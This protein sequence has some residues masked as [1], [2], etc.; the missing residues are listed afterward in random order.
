MAARY[1]RGTKVWER[2]DHGV[3]GSRLLCG[4]PEWEHLDCGCQ[5][6][7]ATL[8]AATWDDPYV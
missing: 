2:L 5:A 7:G 1:H 6:C 3:F 8:T 4:E